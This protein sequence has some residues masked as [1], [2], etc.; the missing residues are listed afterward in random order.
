MTETN[1]SEFYTPEDAEIRIVIKWGNE[2]E[3]IPLENTT[4]EY[5]K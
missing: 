2:E 3:V 5:N 4:I 1:A